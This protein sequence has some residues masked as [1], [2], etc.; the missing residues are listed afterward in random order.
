MRLSMWVAVSLAYASAAGAAPRTK[1][2]VKKE[3]EE[4]VAKPTAEER[5]FRVSDRK[6]DEAKKVVRFEVD[7]GV[8]RAHYE[9]YEF[10]LA[11]YQA[12]VGK[13]DE[14]DKNGQLT[15]S[16]ERLGDADATHHPGSNMPAPEGGIRITT[17][18]CHLLAKR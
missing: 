8:Q 1:S 9:T 4:S 13:D 5:A 10:D 12:I 14:G 18:R 11:E 17:I 6:I 3:K 15:L 16:F 7:R 2:P